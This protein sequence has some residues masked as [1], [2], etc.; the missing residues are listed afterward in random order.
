MIFRQKFYISKK[1][2]IAGQ[3]EMGNPEKYWGDFAVQTLMGLANEWLTNNRY[4]VI[5][6]QDIFM[7]I[8]GYK[9][10]VFA[11]GK[12]KPEKP[13]QRRIEL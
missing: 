8:G 13:K 11:E 4:T 2:A 10:T 1:T 7:N 9:L 5:S 12:P 3:V 6:M